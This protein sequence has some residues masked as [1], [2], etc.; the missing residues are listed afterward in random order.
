MKHR[1]LPWIA[2]AVV[3]L[4]VLL[5]IWPAK[6]PAVTADATPAPSAAKAAVVITPS[7][8]SVPQ[9]PPPGA[10]N[11]EKGE[12]EKKAIKIDKYYEYKMP[13]SFYGLVID[14]SGVPISDADVEL[15][16]SDVDGGKSSVLKSDAQGLF[17]LVGAKGKRLSVIIEKKGYDRYLERGKNQ[18]GFEYAS[19]SDEKYHIPNAAKP[20]VFILRKKREAE[21]LIARNN[22]EAELE[23]GQKHTFTIGPRGAVLIVERLPDQGD[24]RL[25]A[26]SARVSVPGGGLALS[27]EEFPVEAPET[28]YVESIEVT[29]KT[30]KPVVW[31]GDNGAALFMKTP[32]GYGRLIIYNTPGMSWVYV[33][34][35]FN[36]NPK[37]RNLELNPAK[38]IK[39]AP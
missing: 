26:W 1:K 22:L 25:R 33:R 5:L 16:W 13:I 19:Y 29:D 23:S 4:L 31:Q 2:L 39:P 35:Y 28:G 24:N 37:S 15:S 27:T 36:P 7:E 30:P 18:Y 34:S 20:V 11:A 38:V 9:P 3:L 10:S 12:W 17:S 21:P 32:Q 14:D 6:K 8:A